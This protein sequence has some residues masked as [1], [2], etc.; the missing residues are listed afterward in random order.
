[1]QIRNLTSD[2]EQAPEQLD[3]EQEAKTEL[4]RQV[5]KLNAEVQQ[6]RAR[7]ESEGIAR[8]EELEEAKRKLPAKLTEPEE[9]VEAALN[10][11]NALE[12]VKARLQGNVEDLMVDVERANA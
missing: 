2:L 5:T 7:F 1:S 9:Q 10:K 3:K 11:C 6:W 12:K 4:Q 8:G